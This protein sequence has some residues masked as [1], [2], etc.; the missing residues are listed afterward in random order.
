MK[1]PFRLAFREEGGF[2]NCYLANGENMEGALLVGCIRKWSV[3]DKDRKRR[4]K[5]L[6]QDS[7]SSAF[8]ESTNTMLSWSESRPAPEHERSGS[9]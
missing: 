3:Q 1:D 9:A 5:E 2:W 7:V 8:L 6:M 4:F